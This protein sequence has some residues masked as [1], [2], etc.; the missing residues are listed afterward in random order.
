MLNVTGNY[1]LGAS[2]SFSLKSTRLEQTPAES[3]G[4]SATNN[5]SA[6]STNYH[7]VLVAVLVWIAVALIRTSYLIARADSVPVVY[8]LG[9]AEFKHDR[10]LVCGQ[11]MTA[12][13]Y[14]ERSGS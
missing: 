8:G 2:D 13:R 3:Y 4:G 10:A 14:M 6:L 5:F 1:Y 9:Y 12:T 7:G 11:K